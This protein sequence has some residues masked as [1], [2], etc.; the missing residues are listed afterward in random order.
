MSN[1]IVKTDI[2]SKLENEIKDIVA[3][4]PQIIKA[5][6]PDEIT[7]TLI[8]LNKVSKAIDS[9]RASL[10][11]PIN[12]GVKAFNQMIKLI[13]DTAEVGINQLSRVQQAINDEIAQKERERLQAVRDA[14][15][16]A[17]KLRAK[18]ATDQML[19]VAQELKVPELIDQALMQEQQSKDAIAQLQA[20]PIVAKVIT[21]S[22]AGSVSYRDN[23]VATV[24]D[25]KEALRYYLQ[26]LDSGYPIGELFIVNQS[27]LNALAKSV[28]R[29]E[30][31]NGI[32][33]KNDKTMV[34]R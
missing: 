21:R 28:K 27:A 1:E 16:E 18:E 26:L 25:K 19:R 34:T 14:E 6:K 4:V 23:W 24:I 12:D 10:V 30:I 20:T 31:K 13:T 8:I 32:Q 5:R 29:E 17:E 22:E 33:I 7:N 15:I 9:E 11:K 3:S 2:I